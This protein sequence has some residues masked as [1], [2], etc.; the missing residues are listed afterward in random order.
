MSDWL[1]TILI[2]LPLAGALVVWLLPVG[3]VAGPIALLVAL[4]EVGFWINGLTSM[5]FD[6][7]GVS[8]NFDQRLRPNQI[9]LRGAKNQRRLAIFFRSGCAGC[10]KDS[11]PNQFDCRTNLL[12]LGSRFVKTN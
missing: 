6:R 10:D 11:S 12:S 7:P 3:R 8:P 4:T 5:D 1:A 2:F 9:I